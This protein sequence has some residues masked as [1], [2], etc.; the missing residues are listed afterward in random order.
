MT[1][2]GSVQHQR[3]NGIGTASPFSKPKQISTYLAT[4]KPLISQQ[5]IVMHGNLRGKTVEAG[6]QKIAFLHSLKISEI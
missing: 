5:T 3:R 2:G 6:V 1:P 4:V